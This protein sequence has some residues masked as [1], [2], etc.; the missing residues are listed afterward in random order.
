MTKYVKVRNTVVKSYCGSTVPR[1]TDLIR[2]GDLEV[3]EFSRI[4][5]Q[6]GTNDI[7]N[8]IDSGKIQ[9]VSVHDVL[10]RFKTLRDVIRKRNS[11]A[12]IIFSSILPR[13]V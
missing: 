11:R 13:Q 5:I 8:L 3:R 9:S 10:R 4:F 6:I 2:F 7:A 1:I 12:L